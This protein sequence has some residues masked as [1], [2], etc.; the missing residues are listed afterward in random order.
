VWLLK[1]FKTGVG[2]RRDVD[3]SLCVEAR[4]GEVHT[5]WGGGQE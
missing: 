3:I 1:G 4:R 2:K 5:S